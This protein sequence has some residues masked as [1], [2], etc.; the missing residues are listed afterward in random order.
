MIWR[1][2]RA[3]A[4]ICSSSNGFAYRK[5]NTDT[6]IRDLFNKAKDETSEYSDIRFSVKNV[7]AHYAEYK[8]AVLNANAALD[9]DSSSIPTSKDLLDS[10]LH[11]LYTEL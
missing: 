11:D 6:E 8:D 4:I 1:E 7:M 5:S 2:W 9:F 3:A 10:A